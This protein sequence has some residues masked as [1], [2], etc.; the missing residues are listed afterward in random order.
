MPRNNRNARSSRHLDAMRRDIASHAARLMAE[1][2]IADFG[3]AKRKAARQPPPK[4]AVVDSLR[5]VPEDKE[6]PD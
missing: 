2:G 5:T 4:G 1:D 3:L 6:D